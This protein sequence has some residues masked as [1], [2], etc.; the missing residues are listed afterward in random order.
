M[1][2][3]TLITNKNYTVEHFRR[4]FI[5]FLLKQN[6]D[7][8]LIVIDD[9]G[10]E[11][12]IDGVKFY[13]VKGNNRSVNPLNKLSL[14]EEIKKQLEIT[15]PDIVF[16]YQLTPNT[17]GVDACKECG[18]KRVY[19][20]IEGLGDIVINNSLKWKF[21]R[22]ISLRLLKKSLSY[23]KKVFLINSD[24]RDYLVKRN[25]VDKEKCVVIPG[26]GVDVNHFSYKSLINDNI[27]LMASRLTKTKGVI[28]YCE[29]ARIIKQKYKDVKFNL[30]G[31][32]FTIKVND[33]KEY[34][35]DGSIDYLGYYKDIEKAYWDCSVN[36]LPSYR[37]GFGLTIAEAG[38]CGR[39]SIVSN[40]EGC[41]DAIINNK[42]GLLFKN[43]N[44]DDLVRKMEYFIINKDK[45]KEMGDEARILAETKFNKDIINKTILDEV[46]NYE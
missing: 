19:P 43:R 41:K 30:I 1:K 35:N 15:K 14:K 36:V 28:E 13:Y 32:E 21:I 10:V 27:F 42:T 5:D 23:S 2:K 16:T 12:T 3:I 45:I 44:V 24:D 39:P 20:M 38:A 29:A 40:A 33:I 11:L 17:F 34:I 31:E 4:N 22:F 25:I 8:S 26:V 46:N 7:L 37:E 6:Y 9:S 18:I